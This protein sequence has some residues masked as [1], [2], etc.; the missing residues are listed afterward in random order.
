MK[1]DNSGFIITDIIIMRMRTREQYENR[2]IQRDKVT[3][4]QG[5]PKIAVYQKYINTLDKPIREIATLAATKYQELFNTT[6]TVLNDKAYAVFEKYSSR[7]LYGVNWYFETNETRGNIPAILFPANL[8]HILHYWQ[9][10]LP[11]KS[12]RL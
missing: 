5:D 7:L 4:L 3:A 2:C 9:R 8:H 10:M 11:T 12:K 6:D 1:S